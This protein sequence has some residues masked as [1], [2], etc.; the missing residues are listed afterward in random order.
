MSGV[1]QMC[2]HMRHGKRIELPRG[3]LTLTDAADAVSE[4]ARY[5]GNYLIF[6]NM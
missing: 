3:G 4:T 2:S 6:S 1:N 5:V